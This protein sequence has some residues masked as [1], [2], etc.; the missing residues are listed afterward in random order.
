MTF[1]TLELIVLDCNS[2]LLLI[3][4]VY[5][6]PYAGVPGP[7]TS[8]P[9][10][11]PIEIFKTAGLKLLAVPLKLTFCVPA[12]PAAI[13]SVPESEPVALDF[14]LTCKVQAWFCARATL[15]QLSLIMSKFVAPAVID[16]IKAV[17]EN[18]PVLL[19]VTVIAVP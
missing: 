15:L 17:V 3:V 9:L 18:A 14:G 4:T 8:I 10:L 1:V 11:L 6:V 2:P 12:A 7:T 19:T 5:Q 16:V 13:C